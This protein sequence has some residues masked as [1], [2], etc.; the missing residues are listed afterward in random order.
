MARRHKSQKSRQLRLAAV[1][2]VCWILMA[3]NCG[4]GGT[5]D[6]GAGNGGSVGGTVNMPKPGGAGHRIEQRIQGNAPEDAYRSGSAAQRSGIS[7]QMGG[8]TQ[9][10]RSDGKPGTPLYAEEGQPGT[11]LHMEDSQPG[12]PLHAEDG[13]AQTGGKGKDGQF[14][15]RSQ[16]GGKAQA[17]GQRIQMDGEAQISEKY[18]RTR[19]PDRQRAK[20]VD[21]RGIYVSGPVAGSAKHMNRLIRLADQTEINA[22]V[23]D[24][25]NDAGQITYDSK[26]PL[27]DH[28]GAD[29]RRTIRDIETLLHRLR[30]HRIYTIARVVAFKDPHLA[31]HHPQLAMRRKTGGIW[32]ERGGAIWV[33]PYHREAQ[34]YVIDIAK[35]AARIGFDEIQFDYVRFPDN[36]AKVDREVRF[37]NPDNLTKAEAIEQFLRDASD[38]LKPLGVA[39]SAD[40]FGLTT[41]AQGDMGIGQAWDLLA[42]E[43]DVLSPM[44]YPSHY[45][46]GNYGLKH[47]D[48]HPKEVVKRALADALRKNNALQSE[49][50]AE[51]RPWLQ[52]FT[53]TWIDPHQKYGKKQIQAQIEAAAEL[54]IRQYLLWNP[55]CEYRALLAS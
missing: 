28:I 4:C 20:A 18:P 39:V 37:H 16:A 53:A 50:K 51:I 32:K 40:V 43:V 26:V 22:M 11:P 14:R 44:I 29:R 17:D 31:A 33:D 10:D 34:Q 24:V 48:L 55:K 52:A 25:K 27:A 38:E 19:S 54:G 8:Q 47:P 9:F 46:A 35:E 7:N 1:I 21:V 12:T 3:I 13:H 23:I 49:K 36:G 30:R 42:D 5:E 45:A 6:R 41:T 15:N 2:T